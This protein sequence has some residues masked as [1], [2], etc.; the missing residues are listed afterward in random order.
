MF[1]TA[2]LRR[3]K[4]LYHCFFMFFEALKIRNG[5]HMKDITMTLSQ[6]NIF[7]SKTLINRLKVKPVLWELHMFNNITI[8]LWFIIGKVNI[9]I[10]RCFQCC[11]QSFLGIPV[12]VFTLYLSETE[13]PHHGW[14]PCHKTFQD[15]EY[16][17]WLKCTFQP[18]LRPIY[19][20]CSKKF[21]RNIWA[22]ILIQLYKNTFT[23][24]RN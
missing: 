17:D 13:W 2:I 22:S 18:G 20:P 23:A 8:K 11:P 15:L 21:D 14:D 5:T 19:K 6:Q 9:N 12:H 16:L 3:N 4:I 10:N 1:L 24:F 7:L